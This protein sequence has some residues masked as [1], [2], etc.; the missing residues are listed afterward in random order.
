MIA[1]QDFLSQSA[2]VV[3][4]CGGGFHLSSPEY[5]CHESNCNLKPILCNSCSFK[6]TENPAVRQCKLCRVTERMKD[7]DPEKEG[8]EI[9]QT[10]SI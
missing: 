8:I 2:M 7:F 1:P 9:D 6:S 10:H 3:T 5:P 4:T